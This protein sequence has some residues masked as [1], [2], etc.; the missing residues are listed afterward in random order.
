[1]CDLDV[2]LCLQ[3]YNKVDQI[4]IEEV[5][6]LARRDH[7]VVIR[8]FL[9]AHCLVESTKY[10][11]Q[12]TP[13]YSFKTPR[14]WS[15]MFYISS[16]YVAVYSVINQQVDSQH[17][18]THHVLFVCLSFVAVVWAWISTTSWRSSGNT[19]LLSACTPRRGEVH[20][21]FIK[22]CTYYTVLYLFLCL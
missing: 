16:C 2:I 20:C 22:Y 21:L 11:H 10:K 3:V 17:C 1:M 8:W 12:K 14:A 13:T 6:R 5:D 9:K 4:S 15:C 18:K 7:S 19:W